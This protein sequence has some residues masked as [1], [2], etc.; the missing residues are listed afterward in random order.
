MADQLFIIKPKKMA[1]LII[2]AFWFFGS[3]ALITT[4]IFDTKLG[5]MAWAKYRPYVMRIFGFWM[6][7]LS[8]ISSAFE[9]TK[10]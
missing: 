4:F 10:S 5:R 6:N 3:L 2:N 9:G 8:G 7:K 1:D